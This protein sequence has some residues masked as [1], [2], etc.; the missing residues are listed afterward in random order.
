MLLCLSHQCS[1]AHYETPLLRFPRTGPQRPRDDIDPDD[2]TGEI[3]GLMQP[4]F[5]AEH[6]DLYGHAIVKGDGILMG[7]PVWGKDFIDRFFAYTVPTLMAPANLEALKGRCRLVIYHER[8]AK[9]YIHR[10]TGWVRRGGIE[11]SSID[12]DDVMESVPQFLGAVP[13]TA[14]V[15]NILTTWRAGRAWPST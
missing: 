1:S 13:G 7:F 15:G 11:S 12:P 2:P 3:P 9:P 14:V 8:E 6:A 10:L 5:D 4:W